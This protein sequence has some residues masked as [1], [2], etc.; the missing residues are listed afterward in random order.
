[1]PFHEPTASVVFRNVGFTYKAGLPPALEDV[2]FAISQNT[3]VGICGPAGAGKSTL[4][5]LL[6]RCLDPTTGS[7]TL[8]GVDL[9]SYSLP[10][11]SHTI[12]LIP[13]Y[14]LLFSGTVAD[15]IAYSRL[16]VSADEI[17]AAAAAVNIHHLIVRN[18]HGY[19]TH[20]GDRGCLLT[21]SQRQLI[22]LAREHLKNP[23]LLVL[24]DPMA[25]SVNGVD[26]DVMYAIKRISRNRT[27][28]IVSRNL[29]VLAHCDLILNLEHGHLISVNA[30]ADAAAYPAEN[31]PHSVQQA[32]AFPFSV[33][34]A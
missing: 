10:E 4:V 12:S 24:D 3:T 26:S 5:R 19:A 17:A 6:A 21:G 16:K 23:R 2:S 7:I 28:F 11:I 8:H 32:R 29:G 15:N 20:I 13:R 18:R 30:D 31:S 25:M 9:R 34:T 33:S 22:A 27:T 14:P 1:M